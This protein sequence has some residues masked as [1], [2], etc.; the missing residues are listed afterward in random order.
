MLQYLVADAE[1]WEATA[2]VW[3]EA[4]NDISERY[5]DYIK[6]TT[7]RY[8]ALQAQMDKEREAARRNSRRWGLGIFAGYG[9]GGATVGVGFVWRV[10]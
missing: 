10:M 6:S 4:Y 1:S 7:E 8:A 3:E 5:K 9:T 2:K